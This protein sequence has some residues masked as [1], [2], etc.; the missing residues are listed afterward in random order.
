MTVLR[1]SDPELFLQHARPLLYEREAEYGLALG[2]VEALKTYLKPDITPLLL[3]VVQEGVTTAVCV[4]TRPENVVVSHLTDGQAAALAAYFREHQ[5]PLGGAIGPVP[6]VQA[7]CA[8][9]SDAPV[10][11]R[12][13]NRILQ[14]TQVIPPLTAPGRFR[15]AEP[16]DIDMVSRFFHEF[17]VECLPREL[18]GEAKLAS[19]IEDRIN[20][21]TVFFWE[22]GGTPVSSAHSTR[23]TRGGI[24]I[25][26]VYTPPNE[27]GKGYASNLV[28]ALSQHLLD[29]GKRFCVLFT[30]THNRTSNKIY[31]NVGYR[32][33]GT[34]EFLSYT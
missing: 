10:H 3:R 12:M 14:L 18:P 4:Q 16:A 33:I 32:A 30:D 24:A 13:S 22:N 6:G 5:V 27:R 2:L 26:P 31:E 28:A 17:H 11:V 15:M 19:M 1:D 9:Y 34:S 21:E 25:G 8:H 20:R 23:P 29:Q 7:F